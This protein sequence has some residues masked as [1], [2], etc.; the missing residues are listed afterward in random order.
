MKRCHTCCQWSQRASHTF[1][2]S[3]FL[4]RLTQ[5]ILRKPYRR[6]HRCLRRLG[7]RSRTSCLTYATSPLEAP[8]GGSLAAICSLRRKTRRNLPSI[9]QSG[10]FHCKSRAL[11]QKSPQPH[12]LLSSRG[13]NLQPKFA[14]TVE[15]VYSFASTVFYAE[16]EAEIDFAALP[17]LSVSNQLSMNKIDLKSESP[18]TRAPPLPAREVSGDDPI[19]SM[20]LFHC[21]KRRR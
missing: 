2:F 6:Y 15:E 10:G 19:S 13:G 16:T 9:P 20:R 8:A 12:R 14:E 4:M 7:P 21:T 17:R 18:R 11:P 5:A 1:R 3:R